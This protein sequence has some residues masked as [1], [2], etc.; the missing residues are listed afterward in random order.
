MHG[1]LDTV[2]ALQDLW[3]NLATMPTNAL[4]SLAIL[5][6][7]I[8]RGRD[9]LEYLR[10][11]V[12]HILANHTPCRITD[13]IV[14]NCIQEQ[15]GLVIPE[16][17]V[18]IVLKRMS[19]KNY[20]TKNHGVYQI[21]GNL[22]SSQ[23]AVEQRRARV[24]IDRV[25]ASLLEFSQKSGRPL[26]SADQAITAISS[27]LSEFDIT[28][29][30]AYLRGTTIP[31]IDHDVRRSVVLIS[32]Y[33]RQ[34]QKQHPEHFV[35]F[36]IIVQG[37]MLANALLCPDLQNAPRTYKKVT[38]YLDTPL[39]IHLLGCDGKIR[40]DAILEL[41]RLLSKLGARIA[42][43]SHCIDELQGV[44]Y[45]VSS[46][47]ESPSSYNEIVIEARRNG[48]TRSDLLLLAETFEEELYKV[49]VQIVST[50]QYIDEFQIDEEEFA[51]VLSKE[52]SYRNPNAK[53]RD[54]ESVRSIYAIR[55]G[56]PTPSVEKSRAIFVTSNAA[57]ARAA[58]K[59]GQRYSSTVEVSSVV[60]DFS[61]ANMAWLKAPMGSL[62]LPTTRLLAF[63]YAALKPSEGLLDKYLMEIDRLT[64]RGEIS[65]RDH[66]LL[67]SSPLAYDELVDLTL[68][69]DASLSKETVTEILNR[70]SKEIRKE[71]SDKLASEREAH[72][73]TRID[74]TV[75]QSRNR[76]LIDNLYWRSKQKSRRATLSLCGVVIV[77][78]IIGLFTGIGLDIPSHYSW[79]LMIGYGILSVFTLANLVFGCIVKNLYHWVESTYLSW[80][81]KREAEATG[82][83]LSELGID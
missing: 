34:I 31:R 54:I 43:F 3:W 77:L 83:D 18:Q 32:E 82:L 71:E 10:P 16:R 78:L 67:R 39:L 75:Q 56:E 15:F 40:K 1:A 65:E 35:S 5:K 51:Q 59:Y 45:G 63:S 26:H 66:Q 27:F 80:L 46:E 49:K 55:A 28:C 7:N 70:V 33:V 61:L 41:I 17:T 50:P 38:F 57:F 23:L 62:N 20:L 76:R 29:L 6:V 79:I 48:T 73:M 72:K 19:R 68:G 42:T 64:L 22:P 53:T 24:H 36:L 60:T 13:H 12:L 74:L 81:L 8:D 9:Y 14:S 25:V 11:F 47:L 4:T 58:W 2:G 44:L 30:R 37:H 52:I 69:E 21:S